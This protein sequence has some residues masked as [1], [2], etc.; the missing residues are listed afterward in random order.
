MKGR[1]SKVDMESRLLKMKRDLDNQSWHR[2]WSEKDRCA[3]QHV[4]NSVL[5]IL[6]EYTY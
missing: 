3:G 6:E 2:D 4:L 5:D 1:L